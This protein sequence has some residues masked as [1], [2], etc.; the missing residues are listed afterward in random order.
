MQ[1]RKPIATKKTDMFLQMQPP[2]II[3]RNANGA[4]AGIG[5]EVNP[6]RMVRSQG[7]NDR[8]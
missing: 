4:Q 5:R 8:T 1:G 6:A 2:G 7:Q 3:T